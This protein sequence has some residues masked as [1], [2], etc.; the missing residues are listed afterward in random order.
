MIV[1]ILLLVILL[2][3][4]WTR[5]LIKNDLLLAVALITFNFFLVNVVFNKSNNITKGIAFALFLFLIFYSFKNGFDKNIWVMSPMEIVKQNKRHNFYANDFGKLYT[6]KVSLYYFSKI[7]NPFTKIQQNLFSNL[8][9][10]LYFFASHPRERAGNFEFEKYY[11]VFLP[12][13]FFGLISAVR[14]GVFT[15]RFNILGIY[16]ISVVFISALISQNYILGP[17]L[18]FPF[19]NIV[20]TLGLMFLIKRDLK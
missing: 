6:N 20:L 9:L 10:N 17:I 5:Y 19:I 11:F 2:L 15:N 14:N 7:S 12:V 4:P 3:T 8:D 13:F 1:N 18:F 16:F